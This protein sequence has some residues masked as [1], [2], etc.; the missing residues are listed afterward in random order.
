[1]LLALSQK[2]F[3]AVFKFSGCFFFSLAGLIQCFLQKLYLLLKQ[4]FLFVELRFCR[5]L[6]SLDLFSLSIKQHHFLLSFFK[7]SFKFF[8][9][10]K[11]FLAQFHF[12]LLEFWRSNSTSHRN[13]RRIGIWNF[14]TNSSFTRNW[15]NDTNT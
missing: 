13:H 6:L 4:C 3:F 7:L 14:N 12:C 11:K 2:I 8:F 1:M 15:R 9:L 5:Y 10:G